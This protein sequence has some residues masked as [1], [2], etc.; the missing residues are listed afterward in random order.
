M[1]N[2]GPGGVRNMET[3]SRILGA[4]RDLV[5]DVGYEKVTM[6]GIAAEA[7]VGKQTVYRWWPSKSALLAECVTDGLILPPLAA[8]RDSGDIRADLVAWLV[9]SLSYLG[10]PANA[11]LLRGLAAASADDADLAAV[12]Y[13]RT[14]APLESSITAV[15]QA[16]LVDGRV[17]SGVSSSHV[18]EMFFG[19][20]LYR[21][22]TRQDI[23]PDRAD[24]LV[25]LIMMGIKP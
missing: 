6:E 9:E 5:A 20:I 12:L 18:V 1:A 22:I 23:G 25:D 21:L 3:R 2:R 8:P 7:H 4:T 16:G 14:A 17:R 15:V 19:I 11:S 24:E 10:D 13:A